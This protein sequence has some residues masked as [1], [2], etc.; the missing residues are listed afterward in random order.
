MT[1]K[2]PDS[3]R[4]GAQIYRVEG[5]PDMAAEDGNYGCCN[6]RQFVI[7]IDSGAAPQ[8]QQQT[9]LH[10]ALEAINGEYAIGLEHEQINQLE[11][12]LYALLV[13]N[14]GIFLEA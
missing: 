7:K 13:Q 12:A 14:P 1:G 2:L 8:R 4:I 9:L 10:E 11:G 5:D 6:R 3:I